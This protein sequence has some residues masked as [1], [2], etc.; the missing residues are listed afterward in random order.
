[1]MK[2]YLSIKQAHPDYLLFYRMGDFYELFFEDAIMAAKALDIA[3]TKRG[4]HSGEDIP[5]CGV[6]HHSSEQYLQKLIKSGF[7]VAVCEQMEDPAEAKKRGAKSVVKR[8]VTRIITPGTLTEDNLLES[9]SSNY[10]LSV[11]KTKDTIALAWADISTGNFYVTTVTE[12]E[13]LSEFSRISPKEIL[14]SDEWLSNRPFANAIDDWRKNLTTQV[15][16]FFDS[17]R[18][19][20]K[21]LDFY[22]VKSLEA[23]GFETRAEISACGALIEYLSVTQ[24]EQ[25]PLLAKPRHFIN[26]DHLQIDSST[27]KNLELYSTLSGEYKGSLLAV[28]DRTV[29]NAGARLLRKRLS[30][31][32][33][34]KGAIDARLD[35]VEYFKSNPDTRDYIRKYLSQTPDL[36]RALTRI[37]MGRG[38]PRD[39]III[40]I[41]L[42]ET[43]SILEVL[44]SCD[45][46]RMPTSLLSELNLLDPHDELITLLSESLNDEVPFLAREGGF[47]RHGCHPKLD[48]YRTAQLRSN[49][50]KTELCS[51]YKNLTGVERIKIGDNNLIGMYIEVPSKDI[52]KIPDEFTHRQT[53]ANAV[54]YTTNELRELE[55]KIINAEH[56]AIQLELEI[57]ERLNQEVISKSE[58]ISLTSSA[59]ASLDLACAL[60]ELASEQNYCRPEFNNSNDLKI[61]QGRHPVVESS[62]HTD[63]IANDCELKKGQKISLLTGPN[64]AGKSTF[65]R[66]NALIIIMAQM[67]SFVSASS[68]K[69]GLVDKIF[70]R[71]GASDD[72]ARGQSTFMVEMVETAT[73]LNNATE[74]SFVILDEIGRGTAT[75]DGL[76]IAWAVVEYLHNSNKCRSLFATHYHEL[77]L[78]SDQL[79]NL[80]CN[81]MSIKEWEDDIIFLHK[82]I[83]GTADKSY[84]IHVGK[85]AGLP[86]EVSDRAQEVLQTIQNDD[87]KTT[88]SRLTEDLPLFSANDGFSEGAHAQSEVEVQIKE[89][90]PDSLTPKEAL[91]FLYKLKEKV[92]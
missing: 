36:E 56:S 79:E 54:R 85:L 51:V 63:F 10:L 42:L 9:R 90:N 1:M 78:L 38:G 81:T 64:M 53:L 4:Q 45:R 23:F 62:I 21:I 33:L 65:L 77:T 92:N 48:E 84:G 39:L 29:T 52:S 91:E 37:Y 76:S 3:L 17:S 18:A 44:D 12:K 61:E 58:S 20:H 60:A 74:K 32:L 80:S 57:F 46:Q 82:V 26:S 86:K 40:K 72:L 70:S 71:V 55:N 41:G 16:S 22:S 2:Q 35:L 28:L 67:G 68:A 59:L 87:G 75:F 5:M 7:K 69:I 30:S 24:K 50:L 19:E 14:L 6:P 25:I 47:V 43:L 66:Q 8:E 73:I 13:I 27:R 89:L 49:D 34:S 88:Y 83:P 11:A 15:D 31:P